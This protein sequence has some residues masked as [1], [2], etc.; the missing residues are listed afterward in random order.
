[1]KKFIAV[2]LTVIMFIAVCPLQSLAF[3]VKLPTVESVRFIDDVPVSVKD[4]ETGK[5]MIEEFIDE[6]LKEFEE[7]FGELEFDIETVLN[8]LG[9]ES[10]EELYD[11]YLSDCDY[12]YK[13]EATLSDG[14]VYE[15]DFPE[16]RAEI[17]RYTYIYIDAVVK[18]KDFVAAKEAGESEIPVTVSCEVISDISGIGKES[19]F[20]LYKDTVDCFV[21]SIAPVSTLDTT[22]YED[23]V[24][25][26]LEG[27]SFVITFADSTQKTCKAK[28]DPAED[29]FV[30]DGAVLSSLIFGNKAYISYYDAVYE[31]DITYVDSPY[32]SIELTDY[33]FDEENGLTSVSYKIVK[34]N[35]T[36]KSFTVDVTP[37]LCEELY[38][39]YTTVGF[40]DS[41][42]VTVSCDEIIDW[43]SP[44]YEV[45]GMEL[46]VSIGYLYSD[47]AEL[48]Y[49]EKAE[50][51]EEKDILTVI[52]DI[53]A[54][55]L[56]RFFSVFS[57]IKEMI[58]PEQF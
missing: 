31:F 46:Y 18:Y 54:A 2:I 47:S 10:K 27:E 26:N 11:F 17:D 19:S 41:M 8:I 39:F 49:V 32:E 38:P 13:V 9:Y 25:P 58:A 21:K 33:D 14:S 55:I 51:E 35:G 20:V 29:E 16:G 23:S 57:F 24:M 6:M 4:I 36:S 37:Y 3:T 34:N 43:E 42:P 28:F 56:T 22:Y 1:M 15:I 53:I 40:Y 44:D 52:E 50:E 7:E 45:I 48:P 12:G 30:L 5:E